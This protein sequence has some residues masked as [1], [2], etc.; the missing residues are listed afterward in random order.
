MKHVKEQQIMR[1]NPGQSFK[2]LLI[3][4]CSLRCLTYSKTEFIFVVVQ[5]VEVTE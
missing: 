2:A 1:S 3:Q 4:V 5:P